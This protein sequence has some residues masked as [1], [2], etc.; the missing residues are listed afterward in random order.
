MAQV[1]ARN[2]LRRDMI[3][4]L[5]KLPNMP[6]SKTKA[7][8]E[9]RAQ[10]VKALAHPSRLL[11]AEALIDGEQCVCDLTEVVGADVSTVSKHLLIMKA[12]GLVEAD[13]RGLN[14]FYRLRCPCLGDFFRCVDT[15]NRG[16]MNA[17]KHAAA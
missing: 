9:L 10:V 2:V 14:V 11:I 4:Y 12:A 15:I 16:H 1:A 6:V 5:A 7:R 3:A 8:S 13:K 17:L